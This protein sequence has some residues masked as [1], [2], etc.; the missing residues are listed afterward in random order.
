MTGRPRSGD[1]TPIADL[2]DA[3]LARVGGGR[4]PE[5]TRLARDWDEHAGSPWA[6][7]SRPVRL[8]NAE[9]VVEVQD[10]ASAS[11]LRF[12]VPALIA[13]LDGALGHGVVASVRLRVA[14]RKER[15]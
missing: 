6:G 14:G 3:F 5:L 7:R 15:R 4:A 11:L 9:L 13:R 8:E 12:Q 1:P 10:G 2:L